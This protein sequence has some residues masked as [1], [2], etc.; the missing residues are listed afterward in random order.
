MKMNALRVAAL[1]AGT[2]LLPAQA[3]AWGHTGHVII[4]RLAIQALPADVPAFVRSAQAVQEIGELG[5]EADVSKSTGV[6]SS[7]SYPSIRTVFA[8]HDGE[9]DAGHYVD[10]EDNGAF[11]GNIPFTAAPNTVTPSGRRD[12]DTALRGVG[13][14]QYFVG[15][16]PYNMIDHLQQIRKDFAL[17][18]TFTKAITTA[19][20]P[21]DK[22]FF[23]YQLQLRQTLTLRD[24]GYASHFTGDGSQPMHVSKHFNGWGNYPNPNNYTL[25]PI[26]GPFEGP[27]VKA[28]IT[29]A[30]VQAKMT[31]Y[32]DCA[33]TF[34][35]RVRNYMLA[36]LAQTGPVYEVE[37]LSPL[38]AGSNPQQIDFAA[39]RLAA[40][41]SELR[42]EIVDAWRQSDQITVGFPLIKVS[43]IEAG[44]VVV[45]PALL[46]GD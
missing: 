36:T 15:Y 10:L 28:N 19:A 31:P 11:L 5:A 40:G 16:L 46:A 17:I 14:T 18:R 43:D 25:A 35:V 20:N 29:P 8:V 3:F 42:D 24:I 13:Y 27:F 23:Q 1:L 22:A 34:E 33:C 7:G 41:A 21:A 32:A 37:K 38:F 26:H 4:A 2:A 30:L 9:R 12:Y 6:V 45:T 39:A 44:A